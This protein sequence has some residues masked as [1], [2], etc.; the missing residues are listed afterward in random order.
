MPE[1]ELSMPKKSINT[2]IEDA[3]PGWQPINP[4]SDGLDSRA[5]GAAPAEQ[6]GADSAKLRQKYKQRKRGPEST[7]AAAADK[8][9]EAG[10]VK[11]QRVAPKSPTDSEVGAKTVVIDTRSGKLTGAQG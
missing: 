6:V 3:M 5:E 10:S 1:P 7:A 4:A 2:I 8:T 9:P 11:L